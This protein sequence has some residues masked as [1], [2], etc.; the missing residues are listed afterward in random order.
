ME[1][2]LRANK[3]DSVSRQGA[4]TPSFIWD[5]LRSQPLSA[6]PPAQASHL[7]L[8]AFLGGP[9]ASPV[10]MA[11]QPTR[12]IRPPARTGAPCA[13]T[14]RFHPCLSAVI[15]CNTRCLRCSEAHSLSGV[16]LYVVRTFLPVLLPRRRRQGDGVAR[17]AVQRY[18]LKRGSFKE[19]GRRASQPVPVTLP[20][21]GLLPAFFIF[22]YSPE[23]RIFSAAAGDW[24]FICRASPGRTVRSAFPCGFAPPVSTGRFWMFATR[25][26]PTAGKPAH[27]ARTAPRSAPPAQRL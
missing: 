18:K 8:P 27:S 24:T 6:Y 14:A 23:R 21:Q 9:F 17:S 12:F 4:G 2:A 20:P 25:G 1:K 5:R 11:F 7:P 13:L 10:Y 26:S 22:S 19:G 15:F 3:P 16:A